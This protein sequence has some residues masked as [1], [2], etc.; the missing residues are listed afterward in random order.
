MYPFF[1]RPAFICALAV[2]ALTSC[3]EDED[4]IAPAEV[5]V[6]TATL[7]GATEVPANASTGTG[8]A[9]LTLVGGQ[10]LFRVDVGNIQDVTRAHIHAPAVAG[11]NV[12]I[13]IPLHEDAANPLDFTTTRTLAQGVAPTPIGM[14]LDSLVVLLGNGNAYVNVHT[15][16][17]GPGEIRG[18][19]AAQP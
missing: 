15:V 13:V 2:L 12:G 18:Q 7:S 19:I 17:F 11:V 4:P 1:V 16:A 14:A 8:T 6:F 10:L 9:T 3:S 5:E